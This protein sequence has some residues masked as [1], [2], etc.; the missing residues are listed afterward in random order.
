MINDTVSGVNTGLG[1]SVTV[2]DGPVGG[3]PV[4]ASDPHRDPAKVPSITNIAAGTTAVFDT[5]TVNANYKA[6]DAAI[7]IKIDVNAVTVVGPGSILCRVNFATPYKNASNQDLP[8]IINATDETFPP[9]TPP[10][11]RAVNVTSTGFDIVPD[12]GVAG[13]ATLRL[14]YSVSP[15]T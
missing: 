12:F 9:A 14:R 6:T 13:P 4:A 5:D 3:S 8:P 10:L 1:P 7:K 11:W 2:K 15:A